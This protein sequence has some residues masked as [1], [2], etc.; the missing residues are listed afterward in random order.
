MFS[1]RNNKGSRE[2]NRGFATG[3]IFS[4]VII[5]EYYEPRKVEGEG[6]ISIAKVVHG[7]REIGVENFGDSGDCQVNINCSP[8]GNNWQ[9]E[10]PMIIFFNTNE[11]DYK[12]LM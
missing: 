9:N 1:N 11:H 3:L 12:A 2:S 10:T 6:I 7:Y 5:L 4:S 8:E